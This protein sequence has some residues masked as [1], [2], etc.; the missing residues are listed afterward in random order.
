MPAKITLCPPSLFMYRQ[1]GR[2]YWLCFLIAKWYFFIPNMHQYVCMDTFLIGAVS[3]TSV[4]KEICKKKKK[5]QFKKSPDRFFT[6]IICKLDQIL[7][8]KSNDSV[9]H[10]L[11]ITM[12]VISAAVVW[13]L[14]NT[15][16]PFV[17]VSFASTH[18]WCLCRGLICGQ[19]S[20]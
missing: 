18:V 14:V 9:H 17:R 13:T 15:S 10:V 6:R 20:R 16:D 19:T 2:I 5:I 7:C 4:T 8:Y 11:I 12:A 1:P 3:A